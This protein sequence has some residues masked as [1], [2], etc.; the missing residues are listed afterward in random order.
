MYESFKQM[1]KYDAII[2]GAGISGL[3]TTLM[4]SK[5]LEK[6]L[7]IEKNNYL[8]GVCHSQNID[9]YCVDNG[10]H[11]IT[12]LRDGPLIT[13][14]NKYSNF[15]VKFKPY[16]RYYVRLKGKEPHLAYVP[17]NLSEFAQ[18]SFLPKKDRLIIVK[19]VGEALT[20]L[21]IAPENN[22]KS[23]WDA[24]KKYNLSNRTIEFIDAICPFLSGASTKQTAVSRVIEGAGLNSNKSNFKHKHKLINKLNRF[25]AIK[26]FQNILVNNSQANQG[27]PI[28]GIDSIVKA[29]VCSFPLNYVNVLKNTSIDKIIVKNNT[30]IGVESNNK[31]YFA[32]KIIYSGFMNK[33]PNL[34]DN[35]ILKEEYINQLSNLIPCKSYTL[36]LGMKPYKYF[37][38]T[39][40]EIWFY[41]DTKFWAMP[42]SNYDSALAPKNRQLIGFATVVGDDEQKT[43]E[44]LKNTIL[45]IF[46]KIDK[47]IEFKHEQFDFPEKAVIRTNIKVPDTKSPVEN[48]YLVGTDTE[49][50]SM[51][52]TKAAYSVVNLEKELF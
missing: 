48:L 28:G 42:V 19:L 8:G 20:N 31:K 36:W 23:V 26:N 52:L 45:S 29:I 27:Y 15:D 50:R 22:K 21:I 9:G 41:G 35:G 11:A 4:L 39:G 33:L 49:G 6:C 17:I 30:A 2:I 47:Y 24:I 51:G 16:G 3:L 32:D 7:L 44:N 37:N 10:I 1:A 5:K 46:P 34:I 38:Y 12:E 14:L 25:S 43:R 40:S 13:L 18:A